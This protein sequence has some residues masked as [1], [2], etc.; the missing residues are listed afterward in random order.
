MPNWSDNEGNCHFDVDGTPCYLSETG[1]PMHPG[2]WAWRAPKSTKS[3]HQADIDAAFKR[4][5]RHGVNAAANELDR[6][7]TKR[8]ATAIWVGPNEL[9]ALPDQE[10]K[11]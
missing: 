10:D 7:L 9:R 2:T 3:S 6:L 5:F 8:R 1:C 4:G 11:P